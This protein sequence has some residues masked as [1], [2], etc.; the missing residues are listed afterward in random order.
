MIFY[1]VYDSIIGLNMDKNEHCRDFKG[2]RTK[3]T[4]LNGSI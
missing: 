3:G 4:S 2:L 1:K